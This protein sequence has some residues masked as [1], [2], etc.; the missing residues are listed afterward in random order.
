MANEE[1]SSQLDEMMLI[2]PCLECIAERRNKGIA[3]PTLDEL[4]S[5]LG[6]FTAE[7]QATL[8]E[9]IE[10]KRRPGPQLRALGAAPQAPTYGSNQAVQDAFNALTRQLG[11]AMSKQHNVVDMQIALLRISE[12]EILWKEI[13]KK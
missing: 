6:V 7:P 3:E 13:A 8:I 9:Q 12:A 4:L 1:D 5:F 2:C 10:A 11:G